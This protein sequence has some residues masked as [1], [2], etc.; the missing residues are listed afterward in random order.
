MTARVYLLVV[1]VVLGLFGLGFILLPG[2]VL[3]IYGVGIDVSD[4]TVARAAGSAFFALGVLALL[5]RTA[6]SADVERVAT[7]AL[8]AFFVPKALTTTLGQVQG[9][10][11][12]LGWSV[13]VLDL[14]LLVGAI[15]VVGRGDAAAGRARAGTP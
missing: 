9:A 12:A 6:R 11:N 10:F 14:L 15:W 2:A 3:A 8:L 4:A 1:A 5:A 7:L 13:V